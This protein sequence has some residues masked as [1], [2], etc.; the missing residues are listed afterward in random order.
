ML[1]VH[2]HTDVTVESQNDHGSTAGS[3]CAWFC[4]RRCTAWYFREISRVFI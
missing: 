2:I 4:E 1:A 3:S